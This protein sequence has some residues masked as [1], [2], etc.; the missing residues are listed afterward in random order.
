MNYN[1]GVCNVLDMRINHLVP[2]SILLLICVEAIAQTETS[3]SDFRNT[4]VFEELYLGQTPP[5]T[6]PEIFAPE[7]IS[8]DLHEDGAPY[9]ASEHN[10][11]YWR[12]A[13]NPQSIISVMKF[14]NNKWKKPE[15][16]P[17]V[18][19]YM[20]GR[21]FLT[22]DGKKLYFSSN[23]PVDSSE[24][25]N[26]NY[27]LWVTTRK[28][29]VWGKPKLLPSSINSEF[30]ELDISVSDKGTIFFQREGSP[31]NE[32]D[33]L[34]SSYTDN[35]YS[36]SICLDTTINSKHIEAAPYIASDESYIIFTSNRPEGFGKFD[37]WIS[38]KNK[39][40]I[41]TAP[42][43]MGSNINTEYSEKFASLSPDGK[44]F[45]FVSS[46][47]RVYNTNSK[48]EERSFE[49]LT[50]LMKFYSAPKLKPHFCDIYWVSSKVIDDLRPN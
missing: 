27:D 41:W 18:K 1:V 7:I 33:I 24:K 42:V 6:L 17:F 34:Y 38:F 12:I 11:I 16:S 15:I 47:P 29:A 25:P 13:V 45:F 23:L 9:F 22:K 31:E 46:R 43:N 40:N 4:P 20:T 35:T 39:D 5:D 36:E 21:M 48:L 28:G 30:N 44:Y 50:N 8:T 10:E 14:R 2:I 37:L 3:F 26:D 19:K 49:E 32:Y